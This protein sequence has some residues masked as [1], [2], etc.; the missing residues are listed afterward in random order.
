ML[1]PYPPFQALLDAAPE[2][3][4]REIRPHG[5]SPWVH[6]NG[7][8]GFVHQG[9]KP[10]WALE[11]TFEGQTLQMQI[12]RTHEGPLEQDITPLLHDL[13]TWI[14]NLDLEPRRRIAAQLGGWLALQ[15][16]V[17]VHLVEIMGP[18]NPI[19]SARIP[20]HQHYIRFPIPLVQALHTDLA[21]FWARA[22]TPSHRYSRLHWTP[23]QQP[24]GGFRHLY[25]MLPTTHHA[26]LQ[27]IHAL[28]PELRHIPPL[29]APT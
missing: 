3:W 5:L 7:L 18:D 29:D 6:T 26:R 14:A 25:F 9:T 4:G 10:L 27:M 8:R 21:E 28:R 23:G 19:I 12:F 11:F 2:G 20:G 1:L 24:P 22:P 15:G 16:H 13:W 17:G